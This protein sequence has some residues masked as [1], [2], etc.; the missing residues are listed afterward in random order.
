[1]FVSFYHCIWCSSQAALQYLCSLLKRVT[2][3]CLFSPAAGLGSQRKVSVC[4][5]QAFVPAL[6]TPLP[7][8]HPCLRICFIIS[9]TARFHHKSLSLTGAPVP[10]PALRALM[11]PRK[12]EGSLPPSPLHLHLLS[13]QGYC[14]D[15][16]HAKTAIQVVRK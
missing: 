5:C 7:V 1:M 12:R 14:G 9:V 15:L 10:I 2:T 4:L 6:A 16:L 3:S 11:L 8:A 13:L